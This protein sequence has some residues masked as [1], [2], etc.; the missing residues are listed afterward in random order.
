MA[1]K[2]R[3]EES[4]GNWMDT[5]GDMVTLLLTFFIVLYSF[6]SVEEEKWADIVR[7]FNNRGAN[8]VDQ[9][10]LTVTEEGK[11]PGYNQGA[12]NEIDA[13]FE[14]IQA[15]I[16]ENGL[17][18]DITISKSEENEE[19]LGPVDSNIFMEIQDKISFRPDTS[20]LTE[21][22]YE[23]LDFLG[24]ALKGVDE[25][26]LCVVI[27]GHTASFE[28]SEVD[29]RMLSAERASVISNYFEEKFEIS[30]KKFVPIGWANLFPIGNN[31]NEEGRAK[32][33][34]VEISIISKDSYIGKNKELLKIM[35]I[36]LGDEGY[37][38]Q[39]PKPKQEKS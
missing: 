21:G 30:P 1:R 32:N 15:Y 13:L 19:I 8:K 6:S 33:R 26:V 34:R 14:I 25:K 10:V 35:G 18:D 22:S 37:V 9:I 31:E 39:G 28:A 23:V 38:S 4:G 7:A 2:K 17:E 24:E 27:Q 16:E 11:D 5:Y 36:D 29:S 3:E 20:I 12:T